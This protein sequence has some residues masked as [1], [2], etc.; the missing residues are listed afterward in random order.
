MAKIKVLHIIKSL[1]RG[2][3]EMLLP[4]TLKLHDGTNFEF[5]YIYFLPWKNQMVE[6]IKQAG[7]RVTCIS[8]SNNLQLLKK[9]DEVLNYSKKFEIDI[10]HCHLPWSAFVGRIIYKKTNIPVI[11]TE[12]NV[13]EKF[14]FA[15]KY[16]NKIS[17]NSQS[18]AIGVSKDV[19]QSINR[20]INVKIPVQ[21]VSNGVNTNKFQ[22]DKEK[23]KFIRDE[24]NIP[25]DAI[26]IGNIAVFRKQKGL[27]DWII[28]FK[29]ITKD[30]DNVYGILVGAGPEEEKIKELVRKEEL[31]V[32]LKLPGLQT[33]TVSYFSAM[34]IFM[35]SSLFEG[36]PIALLEAMSMEC[37]I[38]ST[39]AGGVVEAIRDKKDGLL[40]EI[41][42]QEKLATL[43]ISLLENK[44][45][46]SQMQRA[47]RSRAEHNFSL[48]SM[49]GTLE[50]IYYKYS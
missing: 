3:A 39:K 34:N 44:E 17:F 11:Y 43:T 35:M 20:N 28:A 27:E 32:K 18:M 25:S 29:K 10:I 22:R 50:Q 5:H 33:D 41:S 49:V 31:T 26:V 42:D 19:T 48:K 36:L 24:L 1:G 13:Q 7:G 47:A 15:T 4:E 38:V 23:G 16:L 12:H 40:C 6:S 37:A 14:H 2:G 8:A 21:T 30:H 9:H 45:K 46:L